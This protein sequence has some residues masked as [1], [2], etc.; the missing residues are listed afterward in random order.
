MSMLGIAQLRSWRRGRAGLREENDLY[1]ASAEQVRGRKRKLDYTTGSRSL[2]ELVPATRAPRSSDLVYGSSLFSLELELLH[3][4]QDER[5]SEAP[6]D[7]FD[8]PPW[9]YSSACLTQL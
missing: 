7:Q 5:G 6:E 9:I 3:G 8:L 2:R 4:L 1:A